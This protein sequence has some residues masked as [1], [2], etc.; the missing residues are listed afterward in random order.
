MRQRGFFTRLLLYFLLQLRIVRDLVTMTLFILIALFCLYW[1]GVL[2]YQGTLYVHE[3]YI[4][5]PWEV[6]HER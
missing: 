4:P 2:L 6:R 3:K 1:G 5:R